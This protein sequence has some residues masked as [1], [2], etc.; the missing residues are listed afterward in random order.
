MTVL[1]RPWVH[2]CLWVYPGPC[3]GR[4]DVVWSLGTHTSVATHVGPVPSGLVEHHAVLI[5]ILVLPFG[6]KVSAFRS[7]PSADVLKLSSPL[8]PPSERKG[9][10]TPS[11]PYTEYGPARV[12]LKPI[13]TSARGLHFG[14]APS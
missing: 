12:Y 13:C 3:P 6:H 2:D 4:T 14:L 5:V 9:P 7:D 10:L 8:Y 11:T 1:K